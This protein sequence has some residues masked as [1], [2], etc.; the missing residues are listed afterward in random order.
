MTRLKRFWAVVSVGGV[1]ALGVS[2]GVVGQTF[3]PPPPPAPPPIPGDLD[4]L[5]RRMG[6]AVQRLGEAIA[7]DLGATP[8]GRHLV[9]D[10][11][12]LAQAVNE[13]QVSLR[14]QADRFQARRAYS[15]IDVS[16]HHLVN[17]INQP[18]L[19]S[20]AVNEAA[21]QVA[22]TDA[23]IHRALSMNEYPVNYYG[24]NQPPSGLPELQR[25]SHAL[26]DRAEALAAVIR[27][28]FSGP[29]GSRLIQEA[30]NLAQTAD[31]F[32][33]ALDLN[34]R[35]DAT[36]QN[37]FSSV[38][39]LS[40]RLEADLALAPRNDRV[41]DAWQSYQSVE[42]LVRKTLDLPNTPADLANTVL[43]ETPGGGSPVTALAGQLV[44]QVTAFVQVFSQTAGAV[45][46]GGQ[47][48]A[49]SQAL[50]AA[51]ADFRQDTARGISPSQLA[52]EFRDVDAIWQRLARRTN[53]IARGRTGPNIQQVGLMGQTITEI[54]RL[55]GMPGY[56]PVIGPLP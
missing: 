22:Q 44:D 8:R 34:G 3:P 2:A 4:R 21:Q 46:E 40:D 25:L 42:V 36:A 24:G 29:G 32:H 20:P 53:R 26:V 7:A 45:P 38:S 6:E 17:Q 52:F 41:R 10:T 50:Q 47:F 56:A 13:F 15:G 51:A 43:T 23:L 31:T 11:R 27:A 54:H 49:D 14:N 16:W 55:L 37:G 48:L 28:E 9:E 35:L 19:S 33:D 12:E 5:G 1:L 30:V 39:G 18:G